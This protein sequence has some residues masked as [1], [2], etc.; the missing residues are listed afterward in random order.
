MADLINI[1]SK[2]VGIS[3]TIVRTI[4][5]LLDEGNTVPFIARYRKELTEGATDEQLRDFDEMYRYTRNLEAR[6]ADIIR[7]IEEKGLMTDE[8]RKQIMEAET[9]AR[10]EDLY[11]PFKEKKNTKATI[12]KAKGLEPLADMLTKAQMSKEEFEAEAAKFVRDTG[13]VKTSVKDVAEAI[14]GAKDILAEAVSDHADLREDIKVREE[15]TGILACKKTKT[16]DD[17]GVYKI[18]GEYSKKLSDMPS[19]A[20]LAVTRAETEKQLNVKLEFSSDKIREETT[21]YFFPKNYGTCI[22][23][24]QEACEDGLHR[25]LLPSLERE[26]RSDKKRRA[27]ESAIKVFGENLKNLLLTPP[28]K[29]MNVLGFDP[30][31]RT[32]CKLAVVDQTGKFLDKIVIYPTE[33]QKKITEAWDTLKKLVDQYKIDLIVIGNGTA[34]RESEKVVHDFIEKYKLNVKYMITSESGASV[35]SASKLAQDEYPDLDVTIRGAISI[36]HRVQDPLAELTKIDPK[37]IGVGQYQHDVDQKYLKEKLEEKVEDI[38]NSVGVDVN[39]ASYTLL[40]YI[41]GL[42]ETVAKNVI[43]YRDENGKF[44]SK[45]Q[46]KKVKGLGPKAY[47]Q[48]IGFLRIKGG[49][50]ILDETGIHPEIHKQVYALLESEMGIKKKDL[51][52]PMTVEKY[53]ENKIKEWSEK[54]KIGL[55]TLRDVLAELQRPGL[56]PRDE[57]EAPCFSSTILDIK[58]LEIGTKLDGIVRNVTDFGAFVDIGLHSDGLVHKSQMANYFV[59]NPVDVVK[60]GQQVKVK[61]IDIDLEREKVSLSMKDDSA[62]QTPRTESRGGSE[63]KIEYNKKDDTIGESTMKGNITF[64]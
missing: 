40:Q 48:A 12:A 21:K 10:V 49:K 20:Y 43:A 30:A 7:L 8:L 53:P 37:S 4:V 29:G 31:F 28:I 1:I 59:A 33:P 57:L 47:E 64:S 41:A 39:T 32:G 17:K 14:Q 2:K 13:D 9:L 62:P 6:K 16:F 22:C 45:A 18:Y 19:Y 52:L 26:I 60:V 23:Y 46:I 3:P 36:A 34:S 55:E 44:T 5:Q 61:V 27:D 54:Y 56:D 35:Y 15:N 58:D 25:L 42:S 51:K 11:R 24:V 38:V 50:E 63:K